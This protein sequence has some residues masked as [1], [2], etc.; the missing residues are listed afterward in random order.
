MAQQEPPI[1]EAV[2]VVVAAQGRY[3]GQ[4]LAAQAAPAS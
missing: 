3:R 1:L 4:I 2:A